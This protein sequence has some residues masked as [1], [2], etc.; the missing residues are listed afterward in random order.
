MDNALARHVALAAHRSKQSLDDLV[1]LLQNHCNKGE[2]D[3][4]RSGL[5]VVDRKFDSLLKMVFADHPGL[6]QDL[7]DKKQKFGRPI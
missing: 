5:A 6:E 1:D 3:S 7:A 2:G 4:F